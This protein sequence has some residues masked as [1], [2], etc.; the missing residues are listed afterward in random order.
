MPLE[1]MTQDLHFLLS[2]NCVTLFILFYRIEH[3]PNSDI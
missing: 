2:D 3:V 1:D